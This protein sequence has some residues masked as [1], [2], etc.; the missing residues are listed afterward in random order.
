M[1]EG[2]IPEPTP[3]TAPFWDGAAAGELWLQKC[4]DCGRFYFYPRPFCRYCASANVAW[5]RV[6]GRGRLT[7]YVI[8]HRQAPGLVGQ[9]PIIVLVELDEGP[10]MLSTIVGSDPDPSQ[11]PLDAPV[12]VQFAHRGGRAIPVFRLQEKMS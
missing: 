10:R 3:E 8:N 4:D 7:S 12:V 1:S 5:H 6:S 2:P 9:S 11:L